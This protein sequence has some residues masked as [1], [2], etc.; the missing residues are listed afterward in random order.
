MIYLDGILDASALTT[1]PIGTSELNVFIGDNTEAT[2]RFFDG[3]LDEVKIYNRALSKEE[4]LFL[5][6][7]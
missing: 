4:I 2:G 5:A 3:M 6:G 1:E 7:Q